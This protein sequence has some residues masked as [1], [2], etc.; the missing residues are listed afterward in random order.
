MDENPRIS[1]SRSDLDA[2]PPGRTG[3]VAV[4]YDKRYMIIWGGYKVRFIKHICK[5]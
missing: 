5:S 2:I 1:G 3:H 4:S